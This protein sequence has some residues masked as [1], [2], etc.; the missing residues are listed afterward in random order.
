MALALRL[1]RNEIIIIIIV[2][3]LHRG[4]QQSYFSWPSHASACNGI[5]QASQAGAD[6]CIANAARAPTV[7][8]W[9]HY[10]YALIP[11]G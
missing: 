4:D 1:V 8:R 7:C 9:H 6:A 3:P 2:V 11:T 5:S 10:W